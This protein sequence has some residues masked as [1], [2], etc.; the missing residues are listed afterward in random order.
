MYQRHGRAGLMDAVTTAPDFLTLVRV[1]DLMRFSNAHLPHPLGEESAG[2]LGGG[3]PPTPEREETVASSLIHLCYTRCLAQIS[4]TP[5]A[6]AGM[7]W[8]W[9]TSSSSRICR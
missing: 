6:H 3:R 8:N 7:A 1:K 5:P 2:D 4:Q 9:T